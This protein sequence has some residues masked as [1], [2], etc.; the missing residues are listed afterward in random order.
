M[1][2]IAGCLRVHHEF[3]EPWRASMKSRILKALVVIAILVVSGFTSPV[4]ADAIHAGDT[5]KLDWGLSQTNPSG[6][7][8]YLLSDLTTGDSFL[9]F[10]LEM[11]EYFNPGAAMKVE[12]ISQQ[13]VNGGVGG[14]NPDPLSEQTAWLYRHF[15]EGNLWSIIDLPKTDTNQFKLQEAIW[16][17]EQEKATNPLNPFISF[18]LENPTM[19]SSLDLSYVSVVNPVTYAADGSISAYKQSQLTYS[20]VPEPGSLLLL[21]SG[22]AFF[23]FALRRRNKLRFHSRK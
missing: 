5:I 12:G 2:F 23:S 9:S 20:H 4:M 13:A 11:N 10:C 16:M 14:G 18:L 3:D 7:G 1:P 15:R 22:I 17:L 8:P 6:G 21:G 19:P